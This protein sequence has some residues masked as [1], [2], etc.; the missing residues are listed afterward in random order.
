MNQSTS[1][2]DLSEERIMSLKQDLVQLAQIR[3]SVAMLEADIMAWLQNMP[4]V[5]IEGPE[6]TYED[7]VLKDAN[8]LLNRVFQLVEDRLDLNAIREVLSIPRE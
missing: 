8:F 2:N 6:M 4:I 5:F 1:P 3:A 7:I